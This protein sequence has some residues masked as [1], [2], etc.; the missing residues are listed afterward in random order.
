MSKTIRANDDEQT[1][2][3][4]AVQRAGRAVPAEVRGKKGGVGRTSSQAAEAVSDFRRRGSGQELMCRR[5]RARF[6]C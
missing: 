6:R 3:E 1:T 4:R 5:G 2:D